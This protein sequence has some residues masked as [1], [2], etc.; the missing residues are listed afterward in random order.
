MRVQSKAVARRATLIVR[1]CLLTAKTL[2]GPQ[3]LNSLVY[4]ATRPQ[5]LLHLLLCIMSWSFRGKQALGVGGEEEKKNEPVPGTSL[6]LLS[7]IP[8]GD[9]LLLPQSS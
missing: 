1:E 6:L 2:Q 8:S 9:L 5:N 3:T 7:Y 4:P